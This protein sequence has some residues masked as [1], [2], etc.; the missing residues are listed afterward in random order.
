MRPQMLDR[1]IAAIAARQAGVIS[2]DQLVALPLSHTAI[3]K[4]IASGRLHPVFP[5]AYAVGVPAASITAIRVAAMLSTAP[6]FISN[7]DA[8]EEH[9]LVVAIPGPVHVTVA[10]GRRLRREGIVVHRTRHLHP[11][12]RVRRGPLRLTSAARTLVDIAGGMTK[13]RL[14]AS[15]DEGIRIGA[16]TADQVEAACKRSSGRP[17]TGV[18]LGLARAAHLPFERTRSRG[19]ARFLRFCADNELP[20]PLV[21]VPLLDYEADFFWPRQR[22]VVEVDSDYHDSPRARRSDARRDAELRAAGHVV[23]RVREGEMQVRGRDLALRL[24]RRLHRELG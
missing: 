20:I 4:R 3:A 17:G 5:G 23:I 9:G 19:E 24:T 7:R 21:N 8:A 2:R 11:D 14:T 13:P 18:L 12:E 22:L 1:A 16:F 15:F 10:H 6:S